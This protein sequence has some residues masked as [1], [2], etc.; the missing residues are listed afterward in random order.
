MSDVKQGHQGPPP[1]G[2]S[3]QRQ[4]TVSPNVFL[5]VQVASTEIHDNVT[6]FQEIITERNPKYFYCR[7][8]VPKCHVTLKVF[9]VLPEHIDAILQAMRKVVASIEEPIPLEFNGVGNF[10][11]QVVFVK[12]SRNR[13]LKTLRRNLIREIN[14]LDVLE[15]PLVADKYEPH[16]TLLKTSRCKDRKLRQMK[17]E[18]E[19]YEDM[20][21]DY[22]GVELVRSVQLLS[23]VLMGERNGY[24]FS[25]GEVPFPLTS[26]DHQDADHSP[27]CDDPFPKPIQ[28]MDSDDEID[29]DDFYQIDQTSSRPSWVRMVFS[30]KTLLVASL[31]ALLAWKLRR[32]TK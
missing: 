3:F 4:A 8:P 2:V 17:I 23:M 21:D 25:H 30:P 7:V 18:Q 32:S 20:M 9:N 24:Y 19:H 10:D 11:D 13:A 29:E 26:E 5:A 1:K 14:R 15:T 27:Y 6:A 16:L 22:F 28:K 31:V 12:L